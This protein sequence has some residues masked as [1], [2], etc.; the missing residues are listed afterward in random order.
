MA[1]VSNGTTLIDAGALASGIATGSMTLIKTLTASSS[2]TLSFIDGTDSVVLD[3]TYDSYVF[4][5]INIHPAT[6]GAELEFQANAAGASGFNET[7]TSTSFEANHKEDDGETGLSYI[8]SGD[9]AQGTAFQGIQRNVYNANDNGASGT[10]HIY[11][12]SS[13]TFVKY[14]MSDMQSQQL[15][16]V[17]MSI[18]YIH[19]GYFNLTAAI[20]E[21]QFKFSTGNMDSGVIKLYGIGG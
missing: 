2:A 21:F 7:I 16:T 13:T 15:D 19:S 5:F 1:V 17:G 14:F 4:K 6:D 20:D 9:Q 10:L 3:D 18:N 12:I 11:G 8:A